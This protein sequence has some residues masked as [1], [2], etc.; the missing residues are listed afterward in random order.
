M[1][2][3][4]KS[5]VHISQERKSFWAAVHASPDGLAILDTEGF[6]VFANDA[7]YE[8]VNI[9]GFEKKDSGTKINL[10]E[11]LSKHDLGIANSLVEQISNNPLD[12]I[13]NSEI[14]IQVKNKKSP[15]FYS[16]SLSKAN[17]DFPD[18]DNIFLNELDNGK[19]VLW[20]KDITYR[21]EQERKERDLLAT[22]SHDLKGPLGSILT[23]TEILKNKELLASND[24]QEMIQRI[25]ACA[26]NC[27]NIIDDL[28]SA[29]R[30]QDGV[31][32]IKPKWYSAHEILEE[33]F[34][35]YYPTA[36]TKSIN[37]IYK[38]IDES[39][40]VYADRIGLHRVL[41]NL[42]SNALKYTGKNG[43]VT[44][45][46]RRIGKEVEIIVSDNGSGIDQQTSRIMFEKYSRSESHQDING[47]GLGLF[48]T[49]NIID[50]HNGRIEVKSSIGEG[51]TFVVTLPDA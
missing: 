38:P 12:L 14:Q 33:A 13:W 16:L 26:K 49:K 1:Q 51:S 21:K 47:A 48:I 25:A 9:L 32:V 10:V 15:N 31:L 43:E 40:E 28:L 6:A 44:L 45:T 30:I 41:S 39:V 42:I 4:L 37:F 5:A 11:L 50:A 17:Q 22:T 8:F 35:D 18:D 29:R 34:L 7:F 19:F 36:K 27:I 20:I 2:L 46:A 3:K 24:G 23:S